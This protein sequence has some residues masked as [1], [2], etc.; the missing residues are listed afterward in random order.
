MSRDAQETARQAVAS[1]LSQSGIDHE[2]TE[3]GDFVAVLPGVAKLRTTVSVSVGR[4][5]LSLDAFICRAPAE[6]VEEV[7]RLML[8]R[9]PRLF[10]I[11]FAL[12][13]LGDIYLTGRLPLSAANPADLDVLFGS[14]L[15]EADGAFNRLVSLGFASAIEREQAWRDRHGLDDANLRALRH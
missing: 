13:R 3:G 7:Y 9:N 6:N 8:A 4:S 2:V 14:L 10:G 5:A 15:A 1:Y 12:D 11:A